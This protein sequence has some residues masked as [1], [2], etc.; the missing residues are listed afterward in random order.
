MINKAILTFFL[1][2]SVTC[3]SQ[4]TGIQGKT[5]KVNY[6]KDRQISY[7]E[8]KHEYLSTNGK[9]VFIYYDSVCS[10]TQ[11]QRV[12]RHYIH[13][14]DGHSIKRNYYYD[15]LVTINRDSRIYTE[16][17]NGVRDSIIL[18]MDNNYYSVILDGKVNPLQIS[19]SYDKDSLV[20]SLYISKPDSISYK[21]AKIYLA[22]KYNIPTSFQDEF[23]YHSDDKFS[24]LIN[25]ID[26]F[27]MDFLI[28]YL[29]DYKIY[30]TFYKDN[31]PKDYGYYTNL[32]RTGTWYRY[33]ENGKLLSKGE[34]SGSKFNEYGTEYDVKKTGKWLYYNKYGCVEKEE[35]W[36]NGVL[37]NDS[38]QKE[39][40]MR[41]KRIK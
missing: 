25:F 35:E 36:N 31:S 19:F 16:R 2:L 37:L 18:N 32:G 9:S 33:R 34:Y 20:N 29:N 17:K 11:K 12:T 22:Q 23:T 14:D 41:K 26:K 7:V 13:F 30:V 15:S 24:L 8:Y 27:R 10:K 5:D 1:F 3:F 40:K 28:Y 21:N 38:T 4:R 39:K 6:Y